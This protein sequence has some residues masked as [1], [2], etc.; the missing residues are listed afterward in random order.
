[1]AQHHK[2][3]ASDMLKL[4]QYATYVVDKHNKER[5]NA[6]KSVKEAYYGY[7]PIDVLAYVAKDGSIKKSV[8]EFNSINHFLVKD[9]HNTAVEVVICILSQLAYEC[10][11]D[12]AVFDIDKIDAD[13]KKLEEYYLKKQK[14]L[15]KSQEAALSAEQQAKVQNE[16]TSA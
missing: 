6:L 11:K 9:D 1:M 4:K 5:D 13:A 10:K 3:I 7:S 15:K 12:V 8:L 2:L 16:E 14:E